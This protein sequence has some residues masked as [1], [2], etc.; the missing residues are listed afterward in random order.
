MYCPKGETIPLILFWLRHYFFP[1][2]KA[3]FKLLLQIRSHK[4][5]VSSPYLFF[6]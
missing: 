3:F 5:R 2:P 1:P 6:C 4:S